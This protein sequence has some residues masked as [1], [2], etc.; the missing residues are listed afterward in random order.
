MSLLGCKINCKEKFIMKMTE[1]AR[2]EI[3]NKMKKIRQEIQERE[4]YICMLSKQALNFDYILEELNDEINSLKKNL[5]E[6]VLEQI[7]KYTGNNN[8]E[9][10]LEVYRDAETAFDMLYFS[11]REK[12]EEERKELYGFIKNMMEKFDLTC[13]PLEVFDDDTLQKW[14]DEYE[15]MFEVLYDLND[16]H[17]RLLDAAEELKKATVDAD[18]LLN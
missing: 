17:Y 3:V 13:P 5:E 7:R 6:M 2:I 14:S 1:K 4:K 16:D 8:T 12:T 11:V 18:H 15:K 9:L 10:W